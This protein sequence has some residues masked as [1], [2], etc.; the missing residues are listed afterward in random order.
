MDPSDGA[1][2]S[3]NH[4]RLSERH[5]HDSVPVR[6]ID[7]VGVARNVRSGLQPLNGVRVQPAD[8]ASG[9]FI[10]AGGVM[11]EDPDL[12]E[13]LHASHLSEWCPEVLPY[14]ELPPGWR[15]QVAPDHEDVWFDPEVE[16]T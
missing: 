12:F 5:T 6:D 2:G 7:K 11:S 14:L 4:A 1:E 13:P 10:W 16:L 8:G 15:F 9:W 3:R